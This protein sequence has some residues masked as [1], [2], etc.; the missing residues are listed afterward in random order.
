[1]GYLRPER[2]SL[3]TCLGC[4]Q[5]DSPFSLAWIEPCISFLIKIMLHGAINLHGEGEA[6][7]FNGIRGKPGPSGPY[8]A[9]LYSGSALSPWSDM[10]QTSHRPI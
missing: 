8:D 9:A 4:W 7:T 6:Q 5:R 3:N 1:M 2:E 10:G